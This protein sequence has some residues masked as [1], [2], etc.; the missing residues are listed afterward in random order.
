[1]EAMKSINLSYGGSGGGH[2][3]RCCGGDDRSV[4][5]IHIGMVCCCAGIFVNPESAKT[6]TCMY[7]RLYQSTYSCIYVCVCLCIWSIYVRK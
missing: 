6:Q 1:V 2:R 3:G 7:N 5:G 4:V